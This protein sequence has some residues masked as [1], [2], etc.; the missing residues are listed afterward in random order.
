MKVLM[1]GWELPPHNSGGLGVACYQLCEALAKNEVDIEFI[2]PYQADH[3]I[4]FMKVTAARPKG[5][6]EILSSGIAYD[7]YK[8][9]YA[10]GHNE[11]KDIYTQS[12]LYEH[13]VSEMAGTMSFDIIHAHDW[14][15]FRAALKVKAERGCPLIVH[16]HSVESDRAGGQPG[17]PLVREIEELAMLAA[18]SVIAVSEL[19]KRAIV[20]DYGINPDKIEVVYNSIDRNMLAPISPDNTYR[21]L[22]QLKRNGY[23]IVS[24]VGRL[25]L[26]KGL[27][28][29]LQAAKLVVERMPKTI[30][31]IVGSGEQY[32]ELI[33]LSADLGIGAN[34]V[35]AGFQ[36]GKPW[37]D[38][39]AA[40]DL[41]VMP[42]VSEPFGLTPLEAGFYGVPSVISKQSGVAE[43]LANCLKVDFWDVYEMANKIIGM[44]N[45]D[46]MRSTMT[47]ALEAELPQ[48][49]WEKPTR[50]VKQ[51]YERHLNGVYA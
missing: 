22:S 20:R 49:S 10:D 27:T 35:F 4:S 43:V 12:R 11:Y 25:T 5:V 48:L 36:R 23:K 15:T 32:Y 17:N 44:L 26:Q 34:V 37:R 21:Y 16:L 42:S 51:L 2:L 47:A 28:N 38:S 14:L 1:L 9:V 18:D 3:N 50:Q 6:L 19:T 46:A 13:A 7:S 29:L 24:N 40:S 41:F 8:Y 33:R 31:L 45:S 39:F 30:F